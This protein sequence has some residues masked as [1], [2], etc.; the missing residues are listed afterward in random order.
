MTW[1]GST[2]TT[3]YHSTSGGRTANI[4][5]VWPKAGAVPY[6]VSVPYLW[7]SL[8]K[9]HRWPAEV[10][11]PGQLAA[12]LQVT[13]L[14]DVIVDRNASDRAAEVR[15]MRATGV[16][17]LLDAQ[18]VRELLGLRSTYFHVH[19]LAIEPGALAASARVVRSS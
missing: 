19:V 14:R 15:V 18:T 11:T 17:R 7:D 4:A 2:A 16:E 3:Y 6:L 10:F 1:N 5:D 9:H 12:R 8:S 13:G